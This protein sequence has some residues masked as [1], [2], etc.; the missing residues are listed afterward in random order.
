MR[1]R[2]KIRCFLGV[3]L[4]FLTVAGEAFA[5]LDSTVRKALDTRLAEY[6]EAIE[7]DGPGV[8]KGECDFLIETCLDSLMR[9]H[10]ALS[11][12]E[13]YRDSHVMGS[14][15]VAIH[16]FDRWR[17]SCSPCLC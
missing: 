12:Y 14:E 13:H 5:Q 16:V 6:F 11:A 17:A 8:Q 4:L 7:F 3:A 1:I 10:V 15:A 9:Q 2:Q